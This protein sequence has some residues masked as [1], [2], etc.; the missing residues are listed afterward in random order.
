[1]NKKIPVVA[2]LA[3]TLV[4]MLAV[5]APVLAE[6]KKWVPVT[7]TRTDLSMSMPTE[8]WF[9]DGNTLHARGG[10]AGFA[11]FDIVGVG[12][13]LHGHSESAYDFNTNLNNGRGVWHWDIMLVFP[14]GTFEGSV[15]LEGTYQIVGGLPFSTDAVQTGTFHGTGDYQGW[16]FKILIE[17]GEVITASMLIP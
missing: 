17:P 13:D 4:M 12:M 16:T 5:V 10:T 6:S 3:F 8:V 11:G 7:V 2:V 14:G 15:Q 9:T 1:M